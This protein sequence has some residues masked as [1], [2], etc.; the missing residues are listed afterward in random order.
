MRFARPDSERRVLAIVRFEDAGRQN[1]RH[2]VQ[3]LDRTGNVARADRTGSRSIPLLPH[4][5]GLAR[6]TVRDS[7]SCGSQFPN[8]IGRQTTA[9]ARTSV[10][11][12]RKRVGLAPPW[13]V[14]NTG[15]M[16]PAALFR[17]QPVQA[18]LSGCDDRESQRARPGPFGRVRLRRE[19]RR[20]RPPR[21]PRFR[22]SRR[23]P[24]WSGPSR[25]HGRSRP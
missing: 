21:S 16:G 3:N 13:L 22:D 4:P 2:Y 12:A 25:E 18:P 6:K 7:G 24:L 23:Y 20:S 9:S 11:V 10:Y 8:T 17:S 14:S 5:A 1:R 19:V 15:R